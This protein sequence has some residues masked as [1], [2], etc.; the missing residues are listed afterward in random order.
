MSEVIV[1]ICYPFII[2]ISDWGYWTYLNDVYIFYACSA[3]FAV[4]TSLLL[5]LCF[6][7]KL[8]LKMVDRW[9]LMVSLFTISQFLID[10]IT[11]VKKVLGWKKN[12]SSQKVFYFKN[13]PNYFFISEIKEFWIQLIIFE[14][15]LIKV[16][17]I[18]YLKWY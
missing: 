9:P 3:V 16:T 17:L 1:C 13:S 11:G 2:L 8:Y 7:K 5:I 15:S 18:F 10:L 4:I 6:Y 12:L 14:Y